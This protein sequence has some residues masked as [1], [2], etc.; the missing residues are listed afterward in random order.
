MKIGFIGM[1][2]VG[3]TFAHLFVKHALEVT[4]IYNRTASVSALLAEEFDYRMVSSPQDILEHADWIFFTVS[5]NALVT[6]IQQMNVLDWR[7]KVAIHTSGVYGIEIFDTLVQQGGLCASIHPAFPF[8]NVLLSI[9][10]L[11]GATCGVESSHSSL[12]ESL[13]VLIK[14]LGCQRMNISTGK[15]ALY[16]VALTIASNY[17]VTLYA[18]A[19]RLL[20]EVGA[21]NANA[22]NVLNSLMAGTISN[23]KTQGL[24]TALTGALSRGDTETL[25]K[26]LQALTNPLDL[27]AY[28]TLARLTYPLIEARG[29]DSSVIETLLRKDEG[30]APDHS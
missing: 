26:H 25:A 20:L 8:A 23:L 29:I 3:Q 4:C 16:H 13:D 1:G 12:D 7:G 17:T 9:E 28:R 24:P 11:A 30:D 15:K 6:L 5:D 22:S 2:K 27:L 21:D 19:E 18:I 10:Q 14:A